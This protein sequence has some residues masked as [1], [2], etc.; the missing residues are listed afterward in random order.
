MP[1]KTKINRS[2]PFWDLKLNPI[3][4]LPSAPDR[5]R[6]TGLKECSISKHYNHYIL[7]DFK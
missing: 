7:K 4:M 1:L 6:L 2:K 3:T 5:A